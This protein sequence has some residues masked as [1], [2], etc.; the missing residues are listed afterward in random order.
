MNA[1]ANPVYVVIVTYNFLPWAEHCLR[2]LRASNYPLKT[3]VVDNASADDTVAL[4]R[5]HFPEVTVIANAGNRGFGA[6]NNQGMAVAVDEGAEFVF[7]LNQDTWIFPETVGRLVDALRREPA[8]GVVSPLHYA[9]DETTLD[10]AFCSY[11]NKDYAEQPDMLPGGTYPAGFINAAAW[12]IHRQCLEDVGGFGDLFFQYGEDRDYV[13]RLRYYR[14]QLGFVSSARIVHDRPARRFNIDTAEKMIWYYTIGSRARL[15]NI[16]TP[17]AWA[18]AGVA[19]WLLR[20]AVALLL[21][22]KWFAI[23]AATKVCY[24]VFVKGTA[25][26]LRYRRKIR[27]GARFLFISSQAR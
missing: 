17:Y 11:L 22:G 3:I 23:R 24:T 26:I 6:A 2:S 14:Y 20:D 4:V 25:E 1:A 7:L 12:L 15:A 27:A 16:N 10:A 9:A 8:Y 13:Q 21:K 18:W 19:A 5:E